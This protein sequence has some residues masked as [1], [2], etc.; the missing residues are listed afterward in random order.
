MTGEKSTSC[1][2]DLLLT[3]WT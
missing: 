3:L 2:E 1:T